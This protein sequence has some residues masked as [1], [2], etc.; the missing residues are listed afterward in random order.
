[1]RQPK[2]R[3]PPEIP[4]ISVKSQ[5]SLSLLI[6]ALSKSRKNTN[7]HYCCPISAVTFTTSELEANLV[8]QRLASRYWVHVERGGARCERGEREVKDHM[9]PLIRLWRE[10]AGGGANSQIMSCFQL[11]SCYV[12]YSRWSLFLPISVLCGSLSRYKKESGR[13][14]HWL[15]Q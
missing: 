2:T 8:N 13:S 4:L 10:G 12:Q 9:T 7:N 6:G 15:Y 11:H 3:R 1:M 14:K 5:Q